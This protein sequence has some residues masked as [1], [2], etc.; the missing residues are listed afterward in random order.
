MST[1][2]KCAFYKAEEALLCNNNVVKICAQPVCCAIVFRALANWWKPYENR[3][4]PDVLV[5]LP[6]PANLWRKA[7]ISYLYCIHQRGLGNCKSISAIANGSSAFI[8]L[9]CHTVCHTHAHLALSSPQIHC[10]IFIQSTNLRYLPIYTRN[11]S[12]HISIIARASLN[13]CKKY[14]YYIHTCRFSCTEYKN[15]EMKRFFRS[16]YKYLS[17]HFEL[18]LWRCFCQ[19]ILYTTNATLVGQHQNLFT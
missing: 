19:P 4:A 7:L 8:H 9:F 16:A 12:L 15:E 18:L 2:R 3:I 6:I 11:I 17:I 1:I 14:V 10:H 13:G 5:F